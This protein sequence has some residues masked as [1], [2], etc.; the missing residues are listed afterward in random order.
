MKTIRKFLALVIFVCYLSEMGAVLAYPLPVTRF[1]G[2]ESMYVESSTI[3]RAP[4]FTSLQY[5]ENFSQGQRFG[6]LIYRSK[7]TDVRIDCQSRRVFALSESFYAG[8][9]RSGRLL[10]SYPQSDEYGSYAEHGSW[11]SELVSIGCN[12]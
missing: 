8:E 11:V 10:G 12:Y 7:A 3:R 6:E 5:V 2:G 9:D 1:E 4:R